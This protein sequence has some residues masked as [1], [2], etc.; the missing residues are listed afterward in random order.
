VLERAGNSPCP[1]SIFGPVNITRPESVLNKERERGADKEGEQH[2]QTLFVF[3]RSYGI[4]EF[5][6]V[7]RDIEWSAGVGWSLPE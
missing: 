1:H 6:E 7:F 5:S 2:F 4:S 3:L